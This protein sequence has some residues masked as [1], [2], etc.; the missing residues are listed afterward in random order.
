MILALRV[1][2][3]ASPEVVWSYVSDPEKVREW[4]GGIKAIVPISAG[5][6]SAGSQLR[7][8]YEFRARE[9]NYLAEVLD[10]ERPLRLVIHLTGGN[11]PLGGYMQEVY[12][13]SASASGTILKQ[14][15]ILYKY[16][17]SLFKEALIF[18][19]LHLVKSRRKKYLFKLKE[20]A[21][22]AD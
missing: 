9:S 6:W 11:M 2:I 21:E 22:G 3:D 14:S 15:L 1:E 10:F 16:G 7:V 17:T 18:F 5:V 20:L 4:H 8:R 13:L 12:E 19:L